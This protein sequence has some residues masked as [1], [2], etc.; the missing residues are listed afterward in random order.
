MPKHAYM[1]KTDDGIAMMLANFDDNFS[2]T[3][4]SKYGFATAD[5]L[6]AKQGRLAWRWFLDGLEL[7]RQWTESV[8]EKKDRLQH[9]PGGGAQA[10]P[11]GSMLPA[12]PTIDLGLGLQPIKWE[13]NFFAYFGS[14]V[15]R[16]K[17]HP[18]YQVA[19]GD[20]LGIEGTEIQPPSPDTV[21]AL[22]LSTGPG[23][24]PQ[25]EVPK[26]VFDG[27]DFQFTVGGGP[28]QTGPFVSTRRYVHVVTLPAA[29]Q[30]AVYSYC[31]Q[32]RYKGPPF[33]QKS[34]WVPHSVHG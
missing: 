3:L 23:G 14:L 1:P 28:V 11:I 16:I 33:G 24:L 8:T 18:D 22:K 17:G 26:G 2:P 31:A 12:V 30:A 6:R 29:G 13:P 32:Y 20:L 15:A 27:F 7:G 21:P 10:M 9:G 5:V 25:L 34:M 19:D 4:S